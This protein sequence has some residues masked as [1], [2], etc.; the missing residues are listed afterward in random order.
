[1]PFLFM[2][3]DPSAPAAVPAHFSCTLLLLLQSA[4]GIICNITS[5][6]V[7]LREVGLIG[8]IVESM[9]GAGCLIKIGA[10]DDP[11]FAD[12]ALQVTLM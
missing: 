10:V 5:R 8:D 2:A 6:A 11:S 12:D 1:M 4:T 9:A 7:G 3:L